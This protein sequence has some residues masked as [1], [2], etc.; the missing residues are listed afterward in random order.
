MKK[1]IVYCV[2][3]LIV[4]IVAPAQTTSY[5]LADVVSITASK[6]NLNESWPTPAAILLRRTG[7]VKALTVNVSL[8]GT[9]TY[10]ADYSSSAGTQITIPM[11]KQEAWFTIIPRPDQLAEPAE[12]IRLTI[13]TS[14]KY[15]ISGTNFT[16]I[17]LAD[18]TLM[19]DEAAN[20]FLV[21][22][23]FGGDPDEITDVK[24]LGYEGWID[25]QI[26][27]PKSY[28]QPIIQQK[29]LGNSYLTDYNVQTT[30]WHQIMRRR[31]PP[32]GGT[33][34]TDILRHK[35]AYCLS[36]I[37]VVS[38][39][40][41][42]TLA[43]ADEGICMYYDRL[44][45]GALGNFRQL[46]FD[47]SIHPAMGVYL[48]HVGNKKPDYAN[49][50]FPDEN[51]ARE[52]MQLFTIGLW[53]LNQDGS[54]KLDSQGQ[55]IPT[56]NNATISNMARVFT[57][58]DWGG[59]EWHDVRYNMI[60][61]EE[62]H[63]TAPKTLLNG[64]QL[65]AGQTTLQDINAALDNLFNHPNTGP[66][67]ARLLIQRLV[68]SNPSPQYISRVAAKFANNGSG[69]RGDMAAVVKQ[70]LLDPEARDFQYTQNNISGKMREPY[71][72]LINLAKTYNAQPPSGDYHEGSQFYEP[73][74]QEVF[75]SPSVFNFYSPN[76]R[77]PGQLTYLNK[78]APEFQIYTAVTS[79]E[80][81]NMIHNTS[82]YS[83]SR[84][85]V[86]TTGNEMKYDFTEETA[87]RLQTDA[88]IKKIAGKVL[89]RPLS[90]HSYQQIYKAIE[91]IH[92]G[93]WEWEKHKVWTAF[94]LVTFGS[95]FN[96]VR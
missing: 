69:V 95:E 49:N 75:M 55:P 10:G 39:L 68:S 3:L 21:Q 47:I 9:A 87:L 56:Y 23:A 57:G 28:S 20:R 4:S 19:S 16:E 82:I 50:I 93:I 73:Y 33:V 44:Y 24:T 94:Y 67:I 46:L 37:F 26:A 74:L 11:G 71:L 64:V 62:N 86:E 5:N 66:F 6:T 91:N 29:N 84:W 41:N 15:S 40:S 70:I 79:L 81:S 92:S 88:L 80:A 17:T 38:Q 63:D 30:F 7:G 90:P 48:S 59:T 34:P 65:P 45:D 54:R 22:A 51:F 35:I 58:L 77:P 43:G 72:T 52:I 53:E 76:F 96:I 78:Y 13:N 83:I 8:S 14:P 31:Y 61:E 2:I 32:A 12:T 60:V 85:G 18:A 25:A 89:T 27:R 1:Q 42:E 36:Q